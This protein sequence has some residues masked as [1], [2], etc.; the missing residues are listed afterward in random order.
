[1]TTSNLICNLLRCKEEANTN[2]R[3]LPLAVVGNSMRNSRL[4]LANTWQDL[5]PRLNSWMQCWANRTRTNKWD[6]F[7]LLKKFTR[8]SLINPIPN[9]CSLLYRPKVRA[10]MQ[11]I[12]NVNKESSSYHMVLMAPLRRP[13]RNLLLNVQTL[14]PKANFSISNN[15][16]TQCKAVFKVSKSTSNTLSSQCTKCLDQKYLI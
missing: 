15:L 2:L 6:R 8:T 12:S 3:K 9:R 11:R 13:K 14:A 4:S 7:H 10:R 5:A 1:M 16:P